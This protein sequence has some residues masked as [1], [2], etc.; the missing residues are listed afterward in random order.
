MKKYCLDCGNP[1]YGRSDKKFCSYQCRN[2]YYNQLNRNRNKLVREINTVLRKNR[3]ILETFMPNGNTHIHKNK[4]KANGFN[5]YYY[6]NT[7]I[8]PN[9]EVYYFCYE[10]GYKPLKNDYFKIINSREIHEMHFT[11]HNSL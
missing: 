6:T 9:G 8:N 2:N 7:F 1:L 3:R 5:F 11:E 4:L 10:Y